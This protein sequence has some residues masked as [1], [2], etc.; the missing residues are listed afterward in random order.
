MISTDIVRKVRKILAIIIFIFITGIVIL[1]LSYRFLNYFLVVTKSLEPAD[2]IVL[3]AGND[4]RRLTAVADLYQRGFAPT[5]LLTNDGIFS[6]WSNE[7][8][9]NLYQVEWAQLELI[10]NGVP[11]DAI[12][13]LKYTQSGTFYDALNTKVFVQENKITSLIVVTSDYHTRRTLWSFEKVFIEQQVKLSVYSSGINSPVENWVERILRSNTLIYEF[14]KL[15]YYKCRFG[16][17]EK[18]FL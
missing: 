14:L 9:R 17:F 6:A 3:M 8:S 18:F 13:K 12:V 5:V 7:Y 10:K 1:F 15:N 16:L 4:K 11:K 2:A